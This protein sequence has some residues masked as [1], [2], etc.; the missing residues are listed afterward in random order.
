MASESQR[1]LHSHRHP[2][3]PLQTYSIQKDL[4]EHQ[5]RFLQSVLLDNS[6]H[7]LEMV[8]SLQSARKHSVTEVPPCSLSILPTN[9]SYESLFYV[10]LQYT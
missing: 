6:F 4:Y 1:H 3:P 8:D 5:L 7:F 2:L 10:S 9:T